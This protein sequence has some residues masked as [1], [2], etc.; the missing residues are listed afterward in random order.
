MK[1]LVGID[2]SEA[3][4]HAAEY[5]CK[6]FQGAHEF[7]L[8][9]VFNAVYT[10]TGSSG[11]RE[12]EKQQ[13][14][15]SLDKLGL[16]RK[17]MK[18]LNPDASVRS[19][20]RSGFL[21]NV[22]KKIAEEHEINLLV[23]GN[24]GEHTWLSS[25]LN[26]AVSRVLDHT[27][28]PLFI[29]PE[30]ISEHRQVAMALDGNKMGKLRGVKILRRLVEKSGNKLALIHI[31][32]EMEEGKELEPPTELTNTDTEYVWIYSN[33][34]MDALIN[35]IPEHGIGT[36]CLV[37]R[38]AQ[39]WRKLVHTTHSDMM[40]IKTRIPLLILKEEQ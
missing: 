12:L 1:I 29:I 23:L 8:L 22:V 4:I 34:V 10:S 3:S 7:I 37:H 15:L 19:I 14:A 16:I 30:T 6:Q 33:N 26:G 21:A 24:D 28:L 11:G 5:A 35:D 36:L 13:A 27:S 2:F 39:G 17:S 25:L 31:T 32:N 38:P 18:E 9:H 20:A 40:S